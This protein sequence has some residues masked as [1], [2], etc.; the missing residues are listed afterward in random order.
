MSGTGSRGAMPD[1]FMWGGSI[2]AHQCEGAWQEDGKGPAI[3]DFATQGSVD[4]P[5]R[6]T[7]TIEP[8]SVYPSHE[9]IDFYHTYP[10][11]IELFASMGF[12][13]LRISIDWSRIYPQG[14]DEKPNQAGI[15][16]YIDVVDCL[17]AHNIEPIVTLYHFEMPRHLA[18]EYGSWLDRRV[19]GLYVRYCKTMFQALRG[20]VH[21]WITTNEMNHVD[22]QAAPA[23][24]FTYILSGICADDLPDQ[25]PQALAQ[26][27]YNM[28]L[29]CAQAAR[30][31][32]EVDSANRIGCVFGITPEYAR[33]CNPENVFRA[34]METDRDFYQ[35]DAL[36][37]GSF[38]RYK[39]LSWEKMGIDVYAQP[40]D[41]ADFAEGTLDFIGLNYYTSEVSRAQGDGE[42]TSLFGGMPNPYLEKS[43]WGWGVDPVGMRYLLNYVYRRYGLP[44]IITENGLG[45]ADVLDDDGCIHDAYRIDYLQ[46]HLK[47]LKRAIRDDH[48][49]CF[50]YLMWGPIDLV[51]ATTGEMRKRYGFIYVDK[52]DDGSGT[53]DR[54][55]KD[56]FFWYKR[57]IESNGACL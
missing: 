32:R 5:R 28:T 8:D 47:Q 1:G 45:V 14:D 56:S 7:K 10:E 24:M 46:R 55:P 51:S 53:G 20:K 2:A 13:A 34:F 35:M 39:R 18:D 57:V 41:S 42:G 21:Y 22:P 44:I 15:A 54:I 3:M 6:F 30:V 52:H 37:R 50:G 4:R 48:V 31:A 12:R 40:E 26:L 19:V 43:A 23:D 27:G 36:C 9:G 29:A 33:D 11:D 49:D 38:P 25:K 17:R 16:H